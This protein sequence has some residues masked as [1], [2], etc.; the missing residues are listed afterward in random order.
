MAYKSPPEITSA[1]IEVGVQKATMSWDKLLVG[2]F[3][4]GAYL[5]DADGNGDGRPRQRVPTS[6]SAA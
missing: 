2:A 3:L 1:S 5:A 4:A 6:R